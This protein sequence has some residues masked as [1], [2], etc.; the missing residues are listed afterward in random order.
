MIDS[1]TIRSVGSYSI[2]GAT[3][4]DCKKVNYI[5]GSNG[6]GKTTISNLLA[7]P[8]NPTYMHCGIQH[9]RISDSRIIVYNRKFRES[10]FYTSD[11]MPGV[12][13]M[14]ENVT[15]QQQQ[16]E[17]L[18]KQKEKRTDEL[19]RTT[20]SLEKKKEELVNYD[21]QFCETVWTQ[22]LKRHETVFR[23]AFDGYRGSK[24][25][26][27]K[28]V[29]AL[30]ETGIPDS[31]DTYESLVARANTLFATKPQVCQLLPQTI[32]SD[33]TETIRSIEQHTLWIT[34]IVG[35]E[36]LP[37]AKLITQLN[38]SDW[39]NKGRTYIS[40]TKI[41]PFCQ[42]A[43]ITTQFKEE[44]ESFFDDSFEKSI[45]EIQL[46][47]SQYK[48]TFATIL[49]GFTPLLSAPEQSKIDT[50]LLNSKVSA[51]KSI[52]EKNIALMDGKITEPSRKLTLSSTIEILEDI[53]SII[54][55]ANIN[56]KAHNTMVDD[57]ADQ[58]TRLVNDIWNYCLHE[59]HTLIMQYKATNKGLQQG[60]IG[61]N[62]KINSLSE[63][64]QMVMKQMN[65]IE[66]STTNIGRSVSEINAL[67]K[68][69]GFDNFSIQ[70]S[71][72]GNNRYILVRPDGTPVNHTLSEGE[73]T[74][75]SF[76]YFMQLIK[77]ATTATSISDK[78]ILVIDDPIC[79][80]DSN[81]MYIVSTLIKEQ[82]KQTLNGNSDVEQVFVFTHNVFFHRELT[83]TGVRKNE[84][85]DIAFWIIKKHEG[86]SI[87]VPYGVTNPIS[88]T[89]TLLWDEIKDENISIV[90]LQNTMRRIIEQYFHMIG[91]DAIIASFSTPAEKIA[92]ESLMHWYND[93]SHSIQDDL[94][95]NSYEQSTAM[96]RHIFRQIFIQ[97]GHEAHYNMMMGI[98]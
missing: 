30:V 34:P 61:I 49:E 22:I 2:E 47:Y 84:S 38:N 16:L 41:C 98:K 55:N 20:E 75:I 72:T 40:N 12:F 15:E 42:Q 31:K 13:M 78:R 26:F 83:H 11:D 44:L 56:I 32:S 77:G 88:S 81:I 71:S 57:F 65:E 35:N 28:K 39:I 24:Q 29:L 68:N 19:T 66:R 21:N 59:Q 48:K 7:S 18:K 58:Y 64:V 27:V 54:S 86:R 52:Y 5:F 94:F 37:I 73:E 97:S 33:I 53:I 8:D 87:I 3:L 74:F 85:P 92:C 1:I 89:Y 6:C 82:V 45:R 17:T 10:N 80:L 9:S 25:A 67:L 69:F 4:S 36:D 46:L 96:Y 91:N 63:Q 76:L 79:S 50:V 62:N 90:S 60:I 14:G 70:L 93:G 95:I 23:Q 51:L 43:T